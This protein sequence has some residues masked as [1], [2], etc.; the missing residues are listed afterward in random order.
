MPTPRVDNRTAPVLAGGP[1]PTP[2]P[3][4]PVARVR[5]HKGK[6][7]V[8]FLCSR[9]LGWPLEPLDDLTSLLSTVT[10]DL[11]TT[12]LTPGGAARVVFAHTIYWQSQSLAHNS[13][14]DTPGTLNGE[15]AV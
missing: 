2:M 10:I 7:I 15:I 8:S 3:P 14:H 11:L 5:F 4:R 9:V 1:A 12:G 6:H 13:P